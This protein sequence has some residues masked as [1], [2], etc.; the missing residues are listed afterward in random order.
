MWDFNQRKAD[1]PN[2]DV[3]LKSYDLGRGSRARHRTRSPNVR[4][5]GYLGTLVLG[6]KCA[7]HQA[8][9][10]ARVEACRLKEIVGGSP[11]RDDPQIFW[12]ALNLPSTVMQENVS[13]GLVPDG[14]NSCVPVGSSVLWRPVARRPI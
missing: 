4:G 13:R 8:P 3:D 2:L 1:P 11:E 5:H 7:D 14:P 9:D 12:A 10:D 6:V